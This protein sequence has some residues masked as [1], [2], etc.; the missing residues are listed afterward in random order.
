MKLSGPWV[1]R[2]DRRNDGRVTR[3]WHVRWRVELHEGSTKDCRRTG[4]TS[5]ALADA[6]ADKLRG[7][8]AARDGWTFDRRGYPVEAGRVAPPTMVDTLR[9][10]VISTFPGHKPSTRAKHQS[11]LVRVVAL[12]LTKGADRDAL[13]AACR[14]RGKATIPTIVDHALAYLR[15][16]GLL[17]RPEPDELDGDYAAGRDWVEARSMAAVD[18]DELVLARLW[19]EFVDDR[20]HAT[21]RTYWAGLGTFFNWCERTG[22]VPRNPMA[23]FAKVRRD[24]VA[25]RV[26]PERVPD[27]DEVQAIA[28]YMAAHHGQAEGD[29]VIVAAYTAARIGEALAFRP[30]TFRRKNGQWWA[31]VIDQ[32]T[33]AT[34]RFA[35]DVREELVPTKSDRS[36]GREYRTVPIPVQYDAVVDRLLRGRELDR[37]APLARG[38]RGAVLNADTFRDSHWAGTIEA[39][40]PYGHRLHGITPHALRH[41]GMTFWLRTGIDFK[42]C[43]I[44]GGWRSLKV[45]LD[46]YAGIFPSDEPEALRLL[47]AGNYAGESK[48]ATNDVAGVIDL[49]AYRQGGRRK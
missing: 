32:R 21:A 41:F 26:D 42:R 9:R 3:V 30:S 24:T 11:V 45:M 23:G 35:W 4:F 34:S 37:E 29:L 46:T 15:D 20:A 33:R 5:K 8:A 14:R 36:G 1:G 25:E 18:V 6:Y 44:W 49:G 19:D 2:D 39:L 47:N 40:F 43:Q 48:P 12:T 10:Y 13:L 22:R 17:G 38:P 27:A 7:A 31:D 28:D 16:V